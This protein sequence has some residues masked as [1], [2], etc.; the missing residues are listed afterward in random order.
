[1]M[2]SVTDICPVH[3]YIFINVIK[4]IIQIIDTEICTVFAVVYYKEISI[5]LQNSSAFTRPF[6]TLAQIAVEIL[7]IPFSLILDAYVVIRI[8]ENAIDTFIRNRGK[9]IENRTVMKLIEQM[10]LHDFLHCLSTP[11]DI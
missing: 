5:S 2:L 10:K 1:M 11:A 8:C 4:G 9:Y 3:P 6:D 7:R